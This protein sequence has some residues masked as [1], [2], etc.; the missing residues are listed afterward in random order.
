MHC[1]LATP[2]VFSNRVGRP[3]FLPTRHN[4]WVTDNGVFSTLGAG[5]QLSS[6]P[7]PCRATEVTGFTAAMSCAQITGR[8]P[9]PE[10]CL[11]HHTRGWLVL[12]ALGVEQG[13]VLPAESPRCPVTSTR[14]EV[15]RV[16][17]REHFC[18]TRLASYYFCALLKMGKQSER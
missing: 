6:R 1:V 3:A 13:A 9:S 14:V 11:S 16:K 2:R 4:E 12:L 10:L 15:G 7:H 18:L 5:S 17:A 8:R